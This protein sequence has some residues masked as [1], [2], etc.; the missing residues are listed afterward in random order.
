MWLYETF[1]VEIEDI[2]IDFLPSHTTSSKMFD[3]LAEAILYAEN[4]G[5]YKLP[6]EIKVC[7]YD[8]DFSE[9]EFSVRT[10]NEDVI[11]GHEEWKP[12]LDFLCQEDKFLNFW[13]N[14]QTE[15]WEDF[16]ANRF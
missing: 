2:V 15:F 12:F 13:R 6:V 5:K 16:H 10:E 14:K 8:E 9:I 1:P 3:T 7:P 11:L 4:K